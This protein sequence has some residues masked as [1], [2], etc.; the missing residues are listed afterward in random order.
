MNTKLIVLVIALCT[1]GVS[2]QSTDIAINGDFETGD[3]TGWTPTLV[4]PVGSATIVS[5]GN[6]ST[7]AARVEVAGFLSSFELQTVNLGAGVVVPGET[8][9]ITLDVRGVASTNLSPTAE[10]LSIDSGGLEI[11]ESLGNIPVDVNPSTWTTVS[12]TATAGPDVTGGVGFRITLIG[13]TT[14]DSLELDNVSVVVGNPTYPG[15]DDDLTLTTGINDSPDGVDVKPAV[16]GD[17]LIVNV[18][19]PG[20][21]YDL[22]PYTLWVQL[23]PTAGGVS[24]LG[25][26]GLFDV[27]LDAALPVVPLIG[28]DNASVLGLFLVAPGGTN[29]AFVLPASLNGL[30]QSL[31]FQSFIS[32]SQSNNGIYAI[33]DAHEIR[34]P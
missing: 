11:A 34:I 18:Q 10:F 23:V 28:A 5:P 4:V 3:F 14:A 16:G 6:N 31:V 30:G 29:H 24:D 7:F 32:T 33:T 26:V 22:F 20:G 9:T 8:V 1:L 21:A 12:F 25:F 19:S 15:S 2:A 27:Y 17:A 13:F